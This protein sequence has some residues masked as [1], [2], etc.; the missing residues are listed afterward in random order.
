MISPTFYKQNCWNHIKD[1]MKVF[2][3]VQEK[4]WAESENKKDCKNGKQIRDEIDRDNSPAFTCE[5]GW[6]K[7]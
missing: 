7:S 1:N 5:K 4:N 3:E 6:G 2:I